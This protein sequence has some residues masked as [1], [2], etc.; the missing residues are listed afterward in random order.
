MN[1]ISEDNI[2]RPDSKACRFMESRFEK[3]GNRLDGIEMLI[4]DK[5]K[6]RSARLIK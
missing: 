3:I 4:R 5:L 1:E 6:T 2:T